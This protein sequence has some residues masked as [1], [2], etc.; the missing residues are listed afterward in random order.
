MVFMTSKANESSDLAEAYNVHG[1]SEIVLFISTGF[2][3]IMVVLQ[4]SDAL[5]MKELG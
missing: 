1:S 4:C 2:S 3:E 5:M